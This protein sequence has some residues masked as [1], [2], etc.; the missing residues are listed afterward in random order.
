VFSV[1]QTYSDG[2]VVDWNGPE[3]S[4]APSPIVQGLSSFGG[5]SSTLTIIALVVA[6]V[7]VLLGGIGL[8]AGRRSLT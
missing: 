5:S 6:A 2:T 4:D 8:T 7:G 1:R 3:S